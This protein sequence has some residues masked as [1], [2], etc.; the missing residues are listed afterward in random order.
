MRDHPI[1]KPTEPFQYRAIGIVRGIY[2][3][4]DKEKFTRGKLITSDGEEIDSVVLGR[5][6]SLMQRH[7][8]IESKHLWVVYPRLR[9]VGALHLQ[10]SG[11]WEP[12]TLFK[13][14]E[15]DNSTKISNKDY[16]DKLPEGDDYFSIRGELIFTKPE[17]NQLVIK[18]RQRIRAN[19]KRPLPFKL[20]LE[21]QLPIEALR[22]FVDLQVRRVGQKLVLEGFKVI[23]PIQSKQGKSRNFRNVSSKNKGS[24]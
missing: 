3:P 7:L 15:E 21:G 22:N 1:P 10:I 9:E 12:S 16:L 5:V 2:L 13:N 14:D 20:S 18:V 11:I 8:V 6:I 17:N 24:S 19:G 23:G 4:E